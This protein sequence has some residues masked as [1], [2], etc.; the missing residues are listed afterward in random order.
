M[1]KAAK[2]TNNGYRVG[3]HTSIAGGVSQAVERAAALNCSTMQIFSHNPRQWHKKVIPEEEIERFISLRQKYDIKPIYIHSSYLINLAS[4]SAKVVSKSIDLLSYELNTADILGVDYV[5]IHIGSSGGESG[6][7]ARG[8]AVKAIMRAINTGKFRSSIL[9]E[10][11]AGKRGDITSSIQDLAEIIDICNCDRI[12][13]I[14]IDTCHAFSSNYNLAS[15]EG[16]VRLI[17]EIRDYIGLDKLRLIHLNDSK[18]PLGSGIDRHEHIGKGFI[19]FRGFK[20]ILS[21]KRLSKVPMIL[22]TPKKNPDDDKKNLGK[23]FRLLSA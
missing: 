11:T 4:V 12:S 7:K 14:C 9:L 13:G 5:V 23:V 8:R 10:N 18:R 1:K 22:E 6:K 15:D 16:L 3:V 20:K 17:R 19:G 21:H 2:G